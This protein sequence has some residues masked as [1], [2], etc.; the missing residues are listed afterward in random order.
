MLPIGNYRS[1]YTVFIGPDGREQRLDCVGFVGPFNAY[2]LSEVSRLYGV[3]ALDRSIL[4]GE[5]FRS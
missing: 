5:H 4:L 2:R 1:F 3:D